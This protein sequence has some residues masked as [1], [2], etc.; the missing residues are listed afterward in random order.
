MAP[1]STTPK[2]IVINPNI[3]DVPQETKE[4]EKTAETDSGEKKVIIQEPDISSTSSSG[5]RKIT[6]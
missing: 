2:E 5:T 3:L 1:N 6:L 4:E